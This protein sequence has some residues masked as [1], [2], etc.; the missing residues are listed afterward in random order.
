MLLFI[1]VL[2]LL[3][4]LYLYVSIFDGGNP[5]DYAMPSI[6]LLIIYS[7]YVFFIKCRNEDDDSDNE[8]NYYDSYQPY[9]YQQ[10]NVKE[11]YTYE[12]VIHTPSH[13]EIKK[14]L[15]K[16]EK[17]K[18]FRIKRNIASVFAI[19][20]TE[21]YR[22]PRRVKKKVPIFSPYAPK[23]TKNELEEYNKVAKSLKRTCKI[24]AIE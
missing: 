5:S 17:S 1:S 16:L 11:Q 20:I 21:K 22:K 7:L 6:L 14:T 10:R 2:V 23:P 12:Y 8:Y 18:W 15:E 13:E 24:E 19:D 9:Y 3:I 4:A